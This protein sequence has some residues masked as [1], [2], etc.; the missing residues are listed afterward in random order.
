MLL[1]MCTNRDD[2]HTDL[3]YMFVIVVNMGLPLMHMLIAM[4]ADFVD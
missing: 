1:I 2:T 4:S 3:V